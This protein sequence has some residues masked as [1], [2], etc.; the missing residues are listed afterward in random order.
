MLDMPLLSWVF[1]VV[2]AG[3]GFFLLATAVFLGALRLEAAR[4]RAAFVPALGKT[5][6]IATPCRVVKGRA[7][8]PGTL[9]L[10][11]AGLIWDAALDLGGA[12]T[13]SEIQK[14]ESRRDERSLL[15]VF[16][17]RFSGEVL[18]VTRDAGQAHEFRIPRS[19]AR[20]WHSALGEWISR[21]AP[22]P[23]TLAR[24]GRR[25]G[26]PILPRSSS[27]PRST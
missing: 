22:P 8:V 19:C 2:V 18:R 15:G 17:G 5:V 13:F 26:A 3:A 24:E 6:R 21:Y 27:D 16:G 4:R 23:E 9:A 11:P 10:T 25:E 14:I 20:E 1:R 12:A 7:S